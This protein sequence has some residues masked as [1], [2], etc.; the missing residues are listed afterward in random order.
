MPFD[1]AAFE[2][3]KNAQPATP[4][5]SGFDPAA[6]EA[7]KRAQSGGSR[8]IEDLASAGSGIATGLAG[9][10]AM[11]PT[12]IGA[13]AR[14]LTELAAPAFQPGGAL[15]WLAPG[16]TGLE[17]VEANRQ[18]IAQAA[19]PPSYEHVSQTPEGKY[20]KT[21][22]E[23]TGGMLGSGGF[24]GPASQ[25]AK[26]IIGQAVIPGAATETAGQMYEGTPYEQLARIGAGAAFGLVGGALTGGGA[27]PMLT[28]Q[29]V[30][31]DATRLYNAP[32]VKAARL[33]PEAINN[34]ADTA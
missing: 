32:E 25:V 29:M 23:F 14:K 6:F 2:A 12:L 17:Q 28:R 10:A 11:T 13:G 34:L 20:L 1:P 31:A 15:S 26:Q 33:T 18:A 21:I 27:P 9:A 30:K 8:F 16:G 4:P 7:F 19:G 5:T 24:S 3:F 22:G